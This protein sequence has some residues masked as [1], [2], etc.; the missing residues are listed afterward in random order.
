[1]KQQ[2]KLQD[3]QHLQLSTYQ[4]MLQQTLAWLTS[5]EKQTKTEPSS[6]TS[7]QEVRGKL[8][9]HKT[10]YQEILGHKRVIEGRS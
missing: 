3:A 6:W 2:Q 8:L 10:T 1:M 9:K 5:M 7:I 4:D